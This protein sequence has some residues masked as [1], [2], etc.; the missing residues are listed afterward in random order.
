MAFWI[1]LA[2]VF[3]SASY[4]M[5]QQA[6]KKAK[7]SADAMAG[8]LLNKESNIEPIPVIYGTRRVGGVR[9]FVSTKDVP[10]G[11]KNEYLYIAHVLCEGKI[12]GI[13]DIRLDDKPM[14][15]TVMTLK[16]T[17]RQTLHL[18]RHLAALF[19]K[20]VILVGIQLTH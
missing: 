11:D 6:M 10:G 15:F 5:S 1:A 14:L 17:I 18:E 4:V 16:H 2:V 7:K 13:S 20:R 3:V 12:T 9:V 8:V 19:C